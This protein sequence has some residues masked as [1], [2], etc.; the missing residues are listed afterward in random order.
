MIPLGPA[1][2]GIRGLTLAP[3]ERELLCDPRV[4]GVLLFTRN[5]ESME[6][7]HR[8]TDSIHTIRQPPL[9]IAVDQE[10]GRVQR[11]RAEFTKLPASAC[12]G[13]LYDRNRHEG[14]AAAKRLGWLMAAELRAVGV[15]LSFAPV[16]DVERGVSRVIGERAFHRQPEAVAELAGGW[17]RGMREAGMAAIGKHFPGHGAVVADSHHELP[18]DRR[19]LEAIVQLDLLPFKRL[20]A[21]GLEGI[22]VAHVLYPQVSARAASFSQVWMGR[23]LREA[24][25][26][27]GATISDDLGMHAACRAGD[28]PQRMATALTS[29]CDLL[30][31]GNELDSAASAVYSL[32]S[33][34][35]PDRERRLAALCGE[36]GRIERSRLHRDHRWQAAVTLATQLA[37]EE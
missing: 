6:Q 30:V 16:L 18:V 22:M 5:Y 25:G 8:L 23:V 35:C 12:L 14:I 31:L 28:L 36:K 19:S 33:I 4:G 15:D 20:I 2:I 10:G 11:F 24:L 37:G 32:P 3:E 9:L 29:G 13:K 17:V 1:M 27:S 7:L 26:F 34:E 21:A